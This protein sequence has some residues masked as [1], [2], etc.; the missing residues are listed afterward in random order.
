MCQLTK[1]PIS[2]SH[3]KQEHTHTHGKA[4]GK[5][6]HYHEAYAVRWC[7]RYWPSGRTDF[8]AQRHCRRRSA[9]SC[10]LTSMRRP[11]Y[12]RRYRAPRVSTSKLWVAF[13]GQAASRADQMCDESP[14]YDPKARAGYSTTS[15][16]RWNA[17]V[18][19][20]LCWPMQALRALS[21]HPKLAPHRRVQ[22]K[23]MAVKRWTFGKSS[24][25]HRWSKA[26]LADRPV[27]MRN[28]RRL[29]QVLVMTSIEA[30]GRCSSYRRRIRGSSGKSTSKLCGGRYNPAGAGTALRP[31]RGGTLR[32]RRHCAGQWGR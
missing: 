24:H 3:P 14:R 11:S 13:F 30:A 4:F 18:A 23:V 2:S 12:K 32:W 31:D 5:S 20:T 19:W 17:T 1:W 26:V 27:R 10:W 8:L 22:D 15:R 25:Y 16:P 6:S 29:A 21:P 9:R 28:R 7:R